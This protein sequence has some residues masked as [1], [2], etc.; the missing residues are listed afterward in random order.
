MTK[1]CK[2]CN[3]EVPSHCVYGDTCIPCAAKKGEKAEVKAS[4]DYEV[5]EDVGCTSGGCTL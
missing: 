5:V 4:T 2:R 3:S 1:L